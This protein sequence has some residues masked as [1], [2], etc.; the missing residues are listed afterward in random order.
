MEG[1]WEGRR[2]EG[3]GGDGA[4]KFPFCLRTH[5]VSLISLVLE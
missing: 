5:Q 4:V 1:E 2:E 3:G